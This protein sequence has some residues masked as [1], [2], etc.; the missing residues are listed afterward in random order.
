VTRL[1]HVGEGFALPNDAVTQT[2]LVL[3]SKGMG[4]TNFGTVLAEELAAGGDRF[5]ILDPVGVWYGLQHDASGK[6]G[7][8]EVLVLGGVHGDLPIEP[9]GGAVIADLVADEDVRVVV[10]FSRKPAG[11]M[12]TAGEQTRFVTDF[13]R[14]LYERQGERR[15]PVHL[16]FDEAGRFVPQM[17]PHG[18]PQLAECVGVLERVVELGRNVGIGV[19]LITQRSAR[20]NKSVAE[21]AECMVAFRTVGPRSVG[22]VVD[23]LGEHIEKSDH[24]AM[25]GKLR[26]LPR[27]SALVV[28]PGWLKREGVVQI[29]PRRTFDTSG[30]PSGGEK[31]ATGKGAKPDLGKYRDRMKETIERAEQEDPR[32][33]R[34]RIAELQVALGKERDRA[35]RKPAAPVKVREVPALKDGQIK[36]L[37]S[38]V[39]RIADVVQ[40]ANAVAEDLS[41]VGGPVQAA[42]ASLLQKGSEARPPTPPFEEGEVKPGWTHV[43]GKPVPRLEDLFPEVNVE[44]NVLTPA[45]TPYATT[46]LRTLAEREPMR[47]TVGQLGVLA[48]KSP[49]SSAFQAAMA[50]LRKQGL[51]QGTG[52]VTLTPEGRAQAGPVKR[53]PTTPREIQEGWLRVLPDYER[54]LLEP[55]LKHGDTSFPVKWLG[56]MANKSPSSSAFQAAMASL[57]RNGLVEG[58]G[59]VRATALARGESHG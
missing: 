10:D 53:A 59:L 41:D 19:T 50:L 38:L 48:G 51:V 43:P 1:L 18:N 33:L 27:G 42:L 16:I 54:T 58:T 11:T 12:W 40:R 32:A 36:R 28:S 14:R 47:L 26:E 49:R 2:L 34:R 17:I 3:G 15:R 8:I 9:S 21:L 46:L 13:T 25:V 57:R 56:E 22:A 39:E 55:L 45:L 35:E 31:R 37:E 24:K 7:G 52:T 5:V 20:I 4:K 29:R 30:T 6:K 23:W 44:V